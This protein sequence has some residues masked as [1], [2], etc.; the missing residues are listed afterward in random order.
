MP[1][2]PPF[3]AS[4]AVLYRCNSRCT[5]C[6]IW[7]REEADPA[8][9]DLVSTLDALAEFGVCLVSLT[10]GEPTLRD[11]LPALVGHARRRGLRVSLTTNGLA[12]EPLLLRELAA[13]GLDSVILSLD[14]VDHAVYESVRGV[15]IGRALSVLSDAAGLQSEGKGPRVSVNAVLGPHSANSMVHLGQLCRE[16]DVALGVQ[17]LHA[18][19]GTQSR[20]P[21]R[22]I[23]MDAEEIEVARTAVEDLL[24]L[25]SEGLRLLNS[26]AYLYGALHFL[27]TGRVP[28][29]TSC[30]AGQSSMAIDHTGAVK[31]CWS[32][33][34]LGEV[35]EGLAFLWS[36]PAY[37]R[38]RSEAEMCDC[39]Q[40]W[41]TCHLDERTISW[42]HEH[43]RDDG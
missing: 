30:P 3:L 18:P 17:P 36:S 40:C 35:D 37:A 42:L 19:F 26:R 1:A 2:D 13:A 32:L 41:L 5:Y 27:A 28:A 12:L 38:A 31:L 21:Q 33:P 8:Y 20:K 25:E 14:S 29:S 22:M 4:V 7:S 10:G 16:L 43:L 34:A 23:A 15:P 24:S 39:P 9:D 6:S 11:D